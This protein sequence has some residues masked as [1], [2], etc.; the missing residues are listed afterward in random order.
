MT[1]RPRSLAGNSLGSVGASGLVIVAAILMPALLVRTLS[2]TDYRDFLIALALL[3]ILLILPQSTRAVGASQLALASAAHDKAW[4]THELIRFTAWVALGQIVLCLFG[5][6]IYLHFESGSVSGD[7]LLRMGLW[8]LLAYTVGLLA[9]G[10]VVSPAAAEKD[11]RPDNVAKA[12]PSLFQIS[13]ILFALV[14]EPERPLL[15]V[16][17]VYVASSW[18]IALL[19]VGRFGR[20]LAAILQQRPERATSLQGQFLFGLGGVIWWNVTAFLSTS[21]S[22]MVVALDHPSALASFSNASALL[23]IVS[24]GLIAVSGPIVLHAAAIMRDDFEAR[25]RFFLSVN[26]GFQIYIL[27]AALAVVVAPQELYALWLNAELAGGVKEFSLLLL[28]AMVIRLLTMSFTMFV[29]SAGRQHK[30]WLSP[31]MEA[32]IASVG[33]IVLSAYIGVR[34]IPLA[35]VIAAA[36]RLALTVIH[37]CA[38]NRAAL[39]LG[40]TD[41]LFPA[42]KIVRSS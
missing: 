5:I 25:R 39:G 20:R 33:C 29:M 37:D 11:F 26:L 15:W 10:L 4:A 22:V 3:P 42:L 1:F 28:P 40:P 21:V 8:A 27:L 16:F 14:V 9:A 34:G 24:G 17:G 7:P 36:V 38:V 32:I 31:L 30:L 23:G 6:E 12:W 19:A 18:S 13:G 41:V 35:L 2:A